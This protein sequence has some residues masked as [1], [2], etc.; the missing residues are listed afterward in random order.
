M[1]TYTENKNKHGV[2]RLMNIEVFP[3][4]QQLVCN[5][6]FYSVRAFKHVVKR[7]T[8]LTLLFIVKSYSRKVG[9]A[10]WQSSI[11]RRI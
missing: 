9:S 7:G 1:Q 2:M 8:V 5:T 3:R 4:H 11:A 10:S 6:A